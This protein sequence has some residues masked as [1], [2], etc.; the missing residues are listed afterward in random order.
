MSDKFSGIMESVGSIFRSGDYLPWTDSDIIANCEREAAGQWAEVTK[1]SD[2]KESIMRLSWAL[3]HSRQ[4]ADVQRGIAM[5]EVALN[6]GGGPLQRKEILYL[7]A[8]GH[9]R[10]GDYTR[11]RRYIEQAL[12]IAPDFRQALTLKKSIEDKITKDGVIGIGIAAT[13]VGLVAGSLAA[14]LARKK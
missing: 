12:Q 8:V 11:S 14:A 7:L 5:L 1:D 6:N 4:A 10:A 13:A 2:K 9:F 3:V